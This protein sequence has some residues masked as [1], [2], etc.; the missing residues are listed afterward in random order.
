MT[1]QTA[2]NQAHEARKRAL[3][4]VMPERD[5]KEAVTIKCVCG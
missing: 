3:R 1:A 4:A 2:V 5:E